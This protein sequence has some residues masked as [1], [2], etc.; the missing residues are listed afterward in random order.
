[1]LAGVRQDAVSKKLAGVRQDALVKC[2]QELGRTP[3]VKEPREINALV[4]VPGKFKYR[5]VRQDAL[6]AGGR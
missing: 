1:M 5:P 3:L 6:V 4:K 2:L